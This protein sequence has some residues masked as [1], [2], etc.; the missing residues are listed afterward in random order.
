MGD[1]SS[2]LNRINKLIS[3]LPVRPIKDNVVQQAA[4]PWAQIAALYDGIDEDDAAADWYRKGAEWAHACGDL[5]GALELIKQ[6]LKL[7]PDDSKARA[8]YVQLWE[9]CG[10]DS[11]PEPID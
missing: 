1:R 3:E 11:V 10:L 4:R 6:S 8:Q 5:L 7:R 2:A 9:L